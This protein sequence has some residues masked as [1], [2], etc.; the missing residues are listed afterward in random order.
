MPIRTETLRLPE[1]DDDTLFSHLKS[2]ANRILSETN[3]KVWTDEEI[4]YMIHVYGA[5][6]QSINA[7]F[8][9]PESLIGATNILR[10][11]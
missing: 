5:N 1:I 9:R 4:K 10:Y 3:G 11:I 6:L 8:A 2:T 7:R